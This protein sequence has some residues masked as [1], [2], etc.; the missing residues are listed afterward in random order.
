MR[1]FERDE[2]KN[3]KKFI[4]FRIPYIE[5]FRLVPKKK[6][7]TDFYNGIDPFNL[8]RIKTLLFPLNKLL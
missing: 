6:F 4:R 7:R 8:N 1:T 2:K 3:E 5:N